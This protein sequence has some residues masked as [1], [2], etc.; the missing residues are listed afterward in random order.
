[1]AKP[2][3]DVQVEMVDF[4]F[5]MPDQIKA[6]PH[7]WQITNSGS[8]WHTM[9][10]WKLNDGVTEEQFMNWFMGDD[11]SNPL[12][13]SVF[14]SSPSTPGMTAWTTLDFTA[15]NYLVLC[16]LPDF[17]DNPPMPH[18]AKGMVRS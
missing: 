6:G 2:V 13:T 5:K 15:G 3:A 17:S 4:S 14:D 8:Q 10:I 18:A 16:P 9:W 7:T 12:G 11:H 1:M